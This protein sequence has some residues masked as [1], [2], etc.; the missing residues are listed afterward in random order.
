MNDERQERENSIFQEELKKVEDQQK[1]RDFIKDR[2]IGGKDAPRPTDDFIDRSLGKDQ[3]RV[4]VVAEAAE[5]TDKRMVQEDAKDRH[6][7]EHA[8]ADR[9]RD[10]AEQKLKPEPD[11]APDHGKDDDFWAGLDKNRERK[12]G[13]E[14]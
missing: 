11:K 7:E 6:L 4:E 5:K 8:R 9:A 2:S 1:E 10:Q 13:H 3:D 14:R 12:R